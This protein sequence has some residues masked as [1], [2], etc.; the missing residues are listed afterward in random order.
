MCRGGGA[1]LLSDG[2]Q[3]GGKEVESHQEMGDMLGVLLLSFKIDAQQTASAIESSLLSLCLTE[4][5]DLQDRE[6][7]KRFL[8]GTTGTFPPFLDAVA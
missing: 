1:P 3:G 5:D 8:P 2:P 7:C 6:Q 4:C